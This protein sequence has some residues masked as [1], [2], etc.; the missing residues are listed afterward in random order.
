MSG[1][2]FHITCTNCQLTSAT[3]P[4]RYDSTVAPSYLELPSLDRARHTFD[5]VSIPIERQ[6]DVE[7]LL[8]IAAAHSTPDVAVCI[9]IF[10]SDSV[11]LRPPAPCPRCGAL[12]LKCP[13][14]SAPA[15][16]GSASAVTDL[17]QLTRGLAIGETGRWELATPHAAVLCTRDDDGSTYRWHISRAGGA[18]EV[19]AAVR[20]VLALLI[21][22]GSTCS[23]PTRMRAFARFDEVRSR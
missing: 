20:E 4:F 19:D 15:P 12:A 13:F 16:V 11:E 7:E 22:G 23:E 3:Y 18:D 17:I 10:G 5:R 6:L 14:G 1:F 8:E 9:P 2:E 21:A